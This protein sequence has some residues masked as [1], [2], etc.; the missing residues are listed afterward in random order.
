MKIY[1]HRGSRSNAREHSLTGY[2]DAISEG[3]DGFECDI[4]L[5]K[6]KKLIL[7]HDKDTSRFS[8]NPQII[9]ETN[10]DDLLID[11][12]LSLDDLLKL[13]IKHKKSLALETKHPVPSKGLVESAVITLLNQ[14][15]QE[16]INA[17]IEIAIYSFSFLAIRRVV[18][19]MGDLPVTPVYL[20]A[21][22]SYVKLLPFIYRAL[23]FDSVSRIGF[24]PSIEMLMTSRKDGHSNSQLADR[25]KNLGAHLYCW[26]INSEEQVIAAQEIGVEY[27]MCDYPAQA[28]SYLR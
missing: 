22:N 4:R 17:N 19:L 13:A 1:A 28:R 11:D 26:T 23:G 16:I 3:A 25:I 18:Q 10:Y 24:G 9:S 6:D 2:L 27:A 7:W 5:T 20:L 12:K 15:R 8:D 21:H 14:H